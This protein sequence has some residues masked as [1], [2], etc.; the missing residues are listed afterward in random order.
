MA[1]DL[2]TVLRLHRQQ[3]KGRLDMR[4]DDPG[5]ATAGASRRA[6]LTGIGAVSVGALLTGCADSGVTAGAGAGNRTGA[7][8]SPGASTDATGPLARTAD[9]PVGGGKVFAAAGI[10]ITQPTAGVFKA[11]SAIC[12]HQQ[13]PLVGVDAGTINC[14]CHGSKFALDD[15]SPRGGP[16]TEPLPAK[17]IQID[18]ED[19]ILA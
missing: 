9:I 8:T 7:G 18:G 6:L 10:V 2:D 3:Q 14:G 16:A 13:C 11:F 1:E 4:N 15:G 17:T 12:T 5:S 19:I